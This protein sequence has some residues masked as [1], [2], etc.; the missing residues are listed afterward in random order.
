MSQTIP[1][2]LQSLVETLELLAAQ[3]RAYE[4]AL[5]P[6]NFPARAAVATL[7]ELARQALNEAYSLA[8]QTAGEQASG[9]GT[10]PPL[11]PRERQALG[12][13]AQ[14]LSNK[15]IAYRLMISERTVQFHINSIFSKTGTHS[16]TEAAA[17]AI[18][19]GWVE[20]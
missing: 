6:D 8:E 17:L 9:A 5:P 14:G 16:R 4:R 20:T 15:E 2:P 19:R 18:R 10:C 11:T 3:C 12:L 7:G 13:V 1:A